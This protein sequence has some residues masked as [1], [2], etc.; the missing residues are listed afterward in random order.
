MPPEALTNDWLEMAAC[1]NKV[2]FGTLAA[3]YCSNLMKKTFLKIT[4][5]PDID[6]NPRN[7]LYK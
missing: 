4:H 1:H 2:I 7:H 5:N 3:V 6:K